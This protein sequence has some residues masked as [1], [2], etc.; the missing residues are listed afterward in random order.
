MYESEGAGGGGTG[1]WGVI[2]SRPHSTEGSNES[3]SGFQICTT[4]IP[5]RL[6]VIGTDK[7]ALPP[8]RCIFKIYAAV[9]NGIVP[10][11]LLKNYYFNRNN[12]TEAYYT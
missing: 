4:T 9:G 7:V 8:F 2:E 12:R 10:A 6:R 11:L 1:W 3:T 5:P